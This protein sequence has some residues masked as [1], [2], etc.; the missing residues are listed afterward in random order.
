MPMPHA[1]KVE[2]ALHIEDLCINIHMAVNLMQFVRI[3]KRF[4]D[5][6][7]RLVRRHAPKTTPDS[8]QYAY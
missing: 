7:Y 3:V 8:R 2:M 4:V 5:L 1:T 6:N